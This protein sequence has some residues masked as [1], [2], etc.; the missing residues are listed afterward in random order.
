MYCTRHRR[1]R[2]PSHVDGFSVGSEAD[3]GKENVLGATG[4]VG[5][6]AKLGTYKWSAI[7]VSFID[8]SEIRHDESINLTSGLL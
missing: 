2:L 4:G 5:W 1:R 8:N 7:G 3:E 6:S